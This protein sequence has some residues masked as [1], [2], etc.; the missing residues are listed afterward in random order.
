MNLWIRLRPLRTRLLL[1]LAVVG[2]GIIT[3]NV[4]ND[5]GGITTYSVA[6]AHYGY[7]L[8]W[9]MPVVAIALVIIQEMSSRLGV[10]T[11][12]GLSS[13]IRE[14]LGVRI[15]AI[16]LGI[17]VIAN[18]A[19]TVS[20][21]AGVA[22]S[23]EIFGVSKYV[24]VP[25]AAVG[26]W[27]LI[28]KGN[29]KTTERIFLIASAIYLA[30]VISGVLAKP[31]WNAAL[32]AMTHPQFKFEANYVT[33]AVTII[34]T[35]IA[36]WMQFYQQSSIVDKGLKVSDYAY[37]RIDVIVG[38][39]FA[40]LVASFITIAC[41]ATL[42]RANITIKDAKDAAL[43]LGP[44]AGNYASILFGLGLLNASVFSA[45]ILPLSTAYVVCEAFGFEAAVNRRWEEAPVFFSIYTGLIVLGALVILLP[46]KSLVEAMMASQTLNGVLLPIILVVMLKLVNDK[47][48]MGRFVNGKILNIINWIVV[49][50][51]I[52]LTVILVLVSIFPGLFG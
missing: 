37:E 46:I 49:L 17:F 35:T 4:D 14:S 21:F 32:T 52:L 9:M 26:V 23:M 29:Y 25:V 41:A 51:I 3:A 38:S 34:G 48:L 15:T 2:P 22:A 27:L 42:F 50:A 12:K 19:N 1:L 13:L 36:P 7:N 20:E 16:I 8:M 33:L 28:V 10:V 39:I 31:D 45:A 24:S 6:G 44:L 40:V 18:L 30:Y 11:G 5:A 47:K 43:A